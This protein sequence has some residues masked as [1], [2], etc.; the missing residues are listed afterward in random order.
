MIRNPQAAARELLVRK[1]IARERNDLG[2]FIE[3]VSG[4]EGFIRPQHLKKVLDLWNRIEAGEQVFALVEAPPRHAKS[5][6]MFHG[7]ARSMNYGKRRVAYSSYSNQFAFRKSR[8]IRE[9]TMAGGAQVGE[10]VKKGDPFQASAA[11]SYWEANGGS[12]IAGGRGGGYKGEGFDL[13][14]IDDPFKNREE[15]ESSVIRENVWQLWQGTLRDRVEPGGSVII[16]H[17][18]W[19]MDDLIGRLKEQDAGRGKWEVVTLQALGD[20]GPL[21]PELYGEKELQSL[22]EDVGEYN[23]FSQFQQKPRPKGDSVFGEA[24]F[25]TELP[26][27]GLRFAFGMDL[28]YSEKTKSDYSVILKGVTDGNFLYITEMH[29][30]QKTILATQ[31]LIS[32]LNKQSPGTPWR[33]YTGGQERAIVSNLKKETGARIKAYPAKADKFIRA[34]PAATNWNKGKIL[35]PAGE[36]WTNEL[37]A[38]VQNFTGTSEDT[39]DDIVDALAALNDETLKAG[40]MIRALMG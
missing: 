25:Y 27:Q 31:A 34:T 6:T 22:R 15:Y 24:H 19:G 38:E 5:E 1:A 7:M 35:L 18:R 28:A 2:A 29:R 33:W 11:V 23:W 17:Q 12:F 26:T 39:H 4:W 40:A 36:R 20:D 13:I 32:E 9:L 37:L 30:H 10:S 16:T 3:R 8:R 14:V 21:W